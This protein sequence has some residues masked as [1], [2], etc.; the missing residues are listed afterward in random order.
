MLL[1]VVF[2]GKVFDFG[3][4]DGRRFRATPVTRRVDKMAHTMSNRG[5]DNGLALL[6]LGVRVNLHTVYAP[7]RAGFLEDRLGLGYVAV[8]DGDIEIRAQFQRA[9]AGNIACYGDDVE[10]GR[11]WGGQEA[12]NESAALL[13]GGAG[14]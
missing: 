4:I 8:H 5:V 13:A 1:N 7:N 14:D 3:R 9:G 12:L 2:S 6:F 10:P 11:V